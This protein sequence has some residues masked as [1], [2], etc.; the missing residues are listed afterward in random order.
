MAVTVAVPVR[1][2]P[3]AI[4]F[5]LPDPV[6]VAVPVRPLEE[7]SL[8][9]YPVALTCANPVID[10]VLSAL[11]LMVPDTTAEAE[12]APMISRVAFIVPVTDAA[13]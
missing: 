12:T 9:R 4:R 10:P 1:L 6:T 11:P 8:A 7:M 2:F 13:D 5:L 3:T